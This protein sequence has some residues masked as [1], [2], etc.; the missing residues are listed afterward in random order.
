MSTIC[1]GD[2]VNFSTVLKLELDKISKVPVNLIVDEESGLITIPIS[3]DIDIYTLL[4][5]KI[6]NIYIFFNPK[7]SKQTPE[8][9]L[10]KIDYKDATSYNILEAHKNIPNVSKNVKKHKLK[11]ISKLDNN[12]ILFKLANKYLLIIDSNGSLYYYP[13]SIETIPISQW[14]L[15]NLDNLDTQNS[16]ESY[17]LKNSITNLECKLDDNAYELLD[18]SNPKLIETNDIQNKYE[19]YSRIGYL[20]SWLNPLT[21]YS[22]ISSKTNDN[23]NENNIGNNYKCNDSI[24]SAKYF[25][26]TKNNNIIKIQNNLVKILKLKK[27]DI[28]MFITDITIN[29]IDEVL[30]TGRIDNTHINLKFNKYLINM[31][32]C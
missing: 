6:I 31:I 7:K 25:L 24:A 14:S 1:A 13:D 9:H 27:I 29:H 30:L 21:Y 26:D 20:L 28:P 12:K 23:S 32:I 16:L 11:M 5:N 10:I 17:L 18:I 4:K 3:Q 15:N 8:I 19:E 22:S 2:I